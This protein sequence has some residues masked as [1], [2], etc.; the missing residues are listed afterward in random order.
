M[1]E[2]SPLTRN[3]AAV[4]HQVASS[5]RGMA[6]VLDPAKTPNSKPAISMA[7]NKSN[8]AMDFLLD[9]LRA[10]RDAVYKDV[11]AEAG[12]KKLK[13][14]PIMW[15][16]AKTLLGIVKMAPRGK[17]KAAR[18]KAAAAPAAAAPTAPKRGPGRPRKST[19]PARSA[20]AASPSF[21]GTI[22][23]IVA[24]VKSSEQSRSRYRAALERIRSIVSDC[25]G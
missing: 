8:P 11:A 20:K 9:S 21:D 25:L 16:R 22:E 2:L 19:K 23:S 1:L 17:G 10:N 14:Y 5:H 6:A 15:G 12:K 4:R 13:V 3:D 18:A 24:A 7:A